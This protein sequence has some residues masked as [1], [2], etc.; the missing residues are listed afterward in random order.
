MSRSTVPPPTSISPISCISYPWRGPLHLH[1]H[2]R[3]TSRDHHRNYS[4]STRALIRCCC[5]PFDTAYTRAFRIRGPLF[6][7]LPG[8]FAIFAAPV[9][10]IRRPAIYICFAQLSITFLPFSRLH[11]RISLCRAPLRRYPYLLYLASP[12]RHINHCALYHYSSLFVR[13]SIHS[14]PHTYPIQ[15]ILAICM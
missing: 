1:H 9:T 7:R 4:L 5:K 10:M 3:T 12:A 15:T 8:P 13:S 14:H 2:L 11:I 6:V